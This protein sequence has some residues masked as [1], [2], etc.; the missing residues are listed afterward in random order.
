VAALAGV[1]AL[2]L[3]LTACGGNENTESG[4][5]GVDHGPL[6]EFMG[7]GSDYTPSEM[8]EEERQKQYRVEELVAECMAEQGFEYIP[9]RYD[10]Q[11][12]GVS[13][14]YEEIWTLQREDPER[15]AKEY[16][17][18][19]TTM[20]DDP[21]DRAEY[22]D[23]NWDIRESLS[24][25][26]QE[27]YDEALWGVWPDFE[28]DEVPDGPVEPEEPGCYSEASDEVYGF[29]DEEQADWEGLDQQFS[30]LYERIE[31]HPRVKEATRAWIDCMAEAGYPGLEEVYGG[32]NLVSDRMDEVYGWGDFAEDLEGLEPEPT[33]APEPDPAELAALQDFE[34]AVG[35]A[36]YLCRRDHYESEYN[37]VRDELENQF[38]EDH[39]AELEAYRDWMA[40]LRGARG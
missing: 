35:Y 16:G 12:S 15:F 8:S 32:H 4:G 17:Y 9:Q 40:E 1:C 30:D 38:I 23:P 13:S 36:D 10:D 21:S 5:G 18:G 22:H 27:A 20:P 25:S 26:A 34:R 6:A 24:P 14:V 31:N 3:L 19:M 29:G 28:V 2:G 39:R 37:A 11:A 33:E 7:W